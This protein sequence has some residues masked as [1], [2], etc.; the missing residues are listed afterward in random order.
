MGRSMTTA[1]L[2]VRSYDGASINCQCRAMEQKSQEIM[3]YHDPEVRWRTGGH[4]TVKIHFIEVVTIFIIF[5]EVCG[6]DTRGDQKESR[7]LVRV[8]VNS[9]VCII[10]Y[11]TK[12]RAIRGHHTDDAGISYTY[13]HRTALRGK[14]MVSKALT[15]DNPS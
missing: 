5:V 11:R 10:N 1:E 7:H 14:R 9:L 15:W 2:W 6:V 13:I 12:L 3:T 4:P 8:A